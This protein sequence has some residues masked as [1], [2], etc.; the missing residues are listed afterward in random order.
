MAAVQILELRPADTIPPGLA[1][2]ITPE[3]LAICRIPPVPIRLRPELAPGVPA[4][5]FHLNATD[6]GEVHI[7]LEL[8]EGAQ[9]DISD[10]RR[11]YLHEISHR[12]SPP[13]SDHDAPFA[14]LYLTLLRRADLL[15]WFDPDYDIQDE[16]GGLGLSL[17]HI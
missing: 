5:C 8:V 15:D 6:R 16:P 14:T 4:E 11:L 1:E 7:L 17:I 3:F 13:S 2:A 12:L 10:I 9:P